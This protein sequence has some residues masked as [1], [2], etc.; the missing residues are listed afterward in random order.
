MS[1][2]EE[3][4]HRW[5][6]RWTGRPGDDA[7]L[8]A[9]MRGPSV[10]CTD[11]CIE[12]VHFE[13]GTSPARAGA[14]AAARTLSDLAASA[15]RPRGLLAALRAP[16]AATEAWI[17]ACLRAVDR[18]GRDFGAPLVGGDL[19]LAPGPLALAITAV[20][21]LE[22]RGGAAPRL[23]SRDRARSGQAL[24]LTGPVG[25]SRLGR[26]LRIEPR[27]ELGQR[28]AALGATAM[29]DVSDG[30]A[31]DLS[32]LAR[33]SGVRIELDRVPIHRDAHRAAKLDGRDAL[34]HA[35]HDGEDHEL[36]AALPATAASKLP[37]TDGQAVGRIVR[38]R[39]LYIQ[40]ARWDGDGGFV[41]G[42]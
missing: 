31:R 33:A 39:G 41:H 42:G 40:G 13:P 26:H 7:A 17:R 9:R 5:I 30:L 28:L 34:W 35:L 22:P 37:A 10:A 18:R 12:G 15:A 19:A 21:E 24:V 29:I 14:K 20:G 2:S 1:W 32:R 27:V 16:K 11:Q 25:G 38:G 36:L 4:L 6:E 8:L 3:R 23:P